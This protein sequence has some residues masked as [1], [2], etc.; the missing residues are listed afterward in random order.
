MVVG[1]VVAHLC[2]TL[3]IKELKFSVEHD[4]MVTILNNQTINIIFSVVF[5]RQGF[6]HPTK[7]EY[8]GWFAQ[9]YNKCGG[10]TFLLLWRVFFLVLNVFGIGFVDLLSKINK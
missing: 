6:K 5:W 4:R 3:I 2:L 10:R 7:N 9:I 1:K 8:M